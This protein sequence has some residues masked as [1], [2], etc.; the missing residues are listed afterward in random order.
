MQFLKK[1]EV[2]HRKY[3]DFKETSLSTYIL[4]VITKKISDRNLRLMLV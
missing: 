1:E 3:R 2:Y 4:F